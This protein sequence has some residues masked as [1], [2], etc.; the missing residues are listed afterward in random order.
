MPLHVRSVIIRFIMSFR[1]TLTLCCKI[2]LNF[3][4]IQIALSLL[5]PR[6]SV[7]NLSLKR[8]SKLSFKKL[9]AVECRAFFLRPPVVGLAGLVCVCT[10]F[11]MTTNSDLIQTF[12][13]RQN[14]VYGRR[15]TATKTGAMSS[16]NL[17][18][19]TEWISLQCCSS[20]FKSHPVKCRKKIPSNLFT[21]EMTNKLIT[22]YTEWQ[23]S[24]SF[25]II[26][27]L[28]IY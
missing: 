24:R 20:R 16:I 12:S 9:Q 26:L 28:L 25:R 21:R 18:F 2:L 5:R 7:R 19:T 11:G 17:Q 14:I 23:T 13:D 22:C 27:V 4:D 3:W 15:L 1:S 8:I 6:R 10:V